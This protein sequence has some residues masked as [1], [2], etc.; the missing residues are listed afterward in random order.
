MTASESSTTWTLVERVKA[1][2]S[3]WEPGIMVLCAAAIPVNVVGWCLPGSSWVWNGYPQGLVELAALLGNGVA[4]TAALTL[5]Q[6]AVWAVFSALLCAALLSTIEGGP[7]LW[8]R[9]RHILASAVIGV[10]L[11]SAMAA[12]GLVTSRQ[13]FNRTCLAVWEDQNGL[14]HGTLKV[15]PVAWRVLWQTIGLRKKLVYTHY[16]EYS[17]PSITVAFVATGNG[18]APIEEAIRK[19]MGD[20]FILEACQYEGREALRYQTKGCHTPDFIGFKTH[21][22]GMLIGGK[23]G[24]LEIVSWFAPAQATLEA[25]DPQACPIGKRRNAEARFLLDLFVKELSVSPEF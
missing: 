24:H 13:V 6:L 3:R 18:L 17:R 22:S 10:G 4:A 20:D 14:A 7:G 19:T 25:K 16:P 9:G 2:W 5:F 1:R 11:C 8:K 21:M 23:F 12:F 15:D